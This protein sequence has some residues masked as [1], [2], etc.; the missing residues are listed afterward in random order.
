MR[1]PPPCTARALLDGD[2]EAEKST[3]EE[4]LKFVWRSPSSSPGA[5]SFRA[6]RP[7]TQRHETTWMLQIR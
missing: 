1:Q 4:V 6:N 3:W 2:E 5:F 7:Q